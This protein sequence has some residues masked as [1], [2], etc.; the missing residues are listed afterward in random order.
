MLL[1][2][3][4]EKWIVVCGS[5]MTCFYRLFAFLLSRSFSTPKRNKLVGKSCYN[6]L[7]FLCE[8]ILRQYITSQLPK[9]KNSYQ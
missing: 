2:V 4:L 9:K 5:P 1:C 6:H 3:L 8:I 7:I